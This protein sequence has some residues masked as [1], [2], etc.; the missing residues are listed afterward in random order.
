QAG[1][2]HL[3]AVAPTIDR[4]AQAA[5][6][7][8]ERDEEGVARRRDKREVAQGAIDGDQLARRAERLRDGGDAFKQA[9]VIAYRPAVGLAHRFYGA[10]A[11]G[12][13]MRHDELCRSP[14]ELQLAGEY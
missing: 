1:D 4:R 14:V 12:H 2:I 10:H 8:V 5:L 11:L 7:V 3:R 13:I 9:L 6:A